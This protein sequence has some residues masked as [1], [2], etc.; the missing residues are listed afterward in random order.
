ML[1][2]N[3]VANYMGN[4]W[5]AIM[6]LAFVPLYVEYLGAEAYGVIGISAVVGTFLSLLD[7]G[8]SPMLSREMASYR[9][10]AHSAESIRSLMRL[11]ELVCWSCGLIGALLVWST[12]P[13]IASQWLRSEVLPVDTIS[14]ALRIMALVV[15]LRFVEGMYRGVLI[16]LQKQ[17]AVNAI[18]SFAATLRGFG[19]IAVLACWSPTLGAFFWW[20]GTVAG[21]SVALFMISSHRAIPR[22]VVKLKLGIHSLATTW[23]FA[24]GI[25]IGNLIGLGLGQIDKVVLS[26]VI[27]LAEY[28]Q[29][30]LATTAASCIAMAAGPIGQAMYPRL[31]EEYSAQ[32]EETLV[33]EFHRM[34]QLVTVLAGG[35]GAVLVAFPHE[36]LLAWTGDPEIA[37]TAATPLRMLSIGA[38][39][40]VCAQVLDYLQ[41]AAGRTRLRNSLN[42]VAVVAVVPALIVLVP[43]YGMSGAAAVWLGLNVLYIAVYAPLSLRD[44]MPRE[45]LRWALGDLAVPLLAALST[46]VA[47]R[48]AYGLLPTEPPAL[49]AILLTSVVLCL[50][51]AA[52][53]APLVRAGVMNVVRRRAVNAGRP[54]R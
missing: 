25:L 18:A 12:A 23:P 5:N 3:I 24:R 11:V 35:V 21:I 53:A 46:C 10:G 7:L 39:L 27:E 30:M 28:G 14:H 37:A 8:L 51:S 36:I 42:G 47:I 48:A 33:A 43:R 6:N 54:G 52:L 44:L 31:T 34:A 2:R 29:Y 17:V 50:V 19:S 16:G 20:Q 38:I 45:L 49:A 41:L 26:R 1:K 40:S 13:W 22:A 32:H 15:C 9:G 4:A